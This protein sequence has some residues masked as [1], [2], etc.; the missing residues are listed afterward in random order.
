MRHRSGTGGLRIFRAVTWFVTAVCAVMV[1]VGAFFLIMGLREWRRGVASGGW[2]AV[3][4]TILESRVA[5]GSNPGRRAGAR[6]PTW[7]AVVRYEYR[8]GGQRF[9]GDRIDF[10]TGGGEREARDDAAAFPVGAI[11][12]VHHDPADPSLAVLRTGPGALDWIPP[13]VGLF[14][15]AFASGVAWLAWR[16]VRIAERVERVGSRRPATQTDPPSSRSPP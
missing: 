4:G 6:S 3:D 12:P 5:Q 9:E 8:V 11:V 14:A 1:L 16:W 15:M 10:R 2:P 7:R 13:A